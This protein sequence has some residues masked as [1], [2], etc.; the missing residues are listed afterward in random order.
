M[1]N[2]VKVTTEHKDE[3]NEEK[4]KY[5]DLLRQRCEVFKKEADE[6]GLSSD[7]MHGEYNY[8]SPKM[9][10]ISAKTPDNPFHPQISVS[11]LLP[12]A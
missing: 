1:E 5:V 2:F 7:N 6:C 11:F 10:L 3:F 9:F 8:I 4:G 12:Y